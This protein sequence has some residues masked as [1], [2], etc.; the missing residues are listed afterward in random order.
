M[1][2]II[3]ETSPENNVSS[4]IKKYVEANRYAAVLSCGVR[5]WWELEEPWKDTSAVVQRE[6]ALLA[7]TL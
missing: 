1:Y 7:S 3:C 4:L 5:A 6:P 2:L